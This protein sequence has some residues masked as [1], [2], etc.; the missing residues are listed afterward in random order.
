MRVHSKRGIFVVL[1]SVLFG[2]STEVSLWAHPGGTDANGCHTCRTNYASWGLSTGQ[3]HCH[4]SGS[5]SSGGSSSSSSGGSTS[6][7]SAS[8]SGGSSPAGFLKI[9]HLD[10]FKAGSVRFRGG[11][12][13][14]GSLRSPLM[15]ASRLR[16]PTARADTMPGDKSETPESDTSLDQ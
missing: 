11:S 9:L 4:N 2:F 6:S 5:S 15:V 1:L 7:S 16:S 13:V 3:Y 14:Q 10:R 12:A 8:S